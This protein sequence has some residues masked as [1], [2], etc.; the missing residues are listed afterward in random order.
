MCLWPTILKYFKHVQQIGLEENIFSL[1]AIAYFDLWGLL[2]VTSTLND[3]AS[4]LSIILVKQA[5]F[6][7]NWK[8]QMKVHRTKL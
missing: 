8:M 3:M 7:Y 4:D 2:L 1:I 6:R 5:V